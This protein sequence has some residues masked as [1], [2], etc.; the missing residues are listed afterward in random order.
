MHVCQPASRISLVGYWALLVRAKTAGYKNTTDSIPQTCVLATKV[1]IRMYIFKVMLS[2]TNALH[3]FI[4]HAEQCLE[5][6]IGYGCG[7]CQ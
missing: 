1:N 7:H 2:C 4:S 6:L 3:F 5:G